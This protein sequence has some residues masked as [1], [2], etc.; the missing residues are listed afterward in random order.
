L[1]R[2]DSGVP[3]QY[4]KNGGYALQS[5]SSQTLKITLLEVAKVP[6]AAETPERLSGRSLR[7]LGVTIAYEKTFARNNIIGFGIRK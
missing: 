7:R 2:V 6:K 1:F 4:T 5:G 3:P